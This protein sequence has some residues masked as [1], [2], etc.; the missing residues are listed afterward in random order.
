M[1]DYNNR[2]SGGGGAPERCVRVCGE[3]RK[4]RFEE[5]DSWALSIW[6]SGNANPIG[7]AGGVRWLSQASQLPP[8]PCQINLTPPSRHDQHALSPRRSHIRCV[9][10]HPPPTPQLYHRVFEL[11]QE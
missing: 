10:M 3:D 9:C 7:L 2:N 1:L 4:E 11:P 8:T 5:E 6:D